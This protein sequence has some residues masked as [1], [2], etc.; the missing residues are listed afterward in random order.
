MPLPP[1]P[2]TLSAGTSPRACLLV[3]GRDI[4]SEKTRAIKQRTHKEHINIF[5]FQKVF[6]KSPVVEAPGT[7][8]IPY[9][10]GEPA[11][12]V[13]DILPQPREQLESQSKT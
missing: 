8:P 6:T 9:R 7:L 2:P 10:H 5:I 3:L 13:P 12:Q 1:S 11:V 4:S